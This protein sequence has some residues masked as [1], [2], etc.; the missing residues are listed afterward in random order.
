MLV[1]GREHTDDQLTEYN[2]SKGFTFPST[3]IPNGK[4]QVNLPPK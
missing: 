4:L 1:I 3:R 2:K